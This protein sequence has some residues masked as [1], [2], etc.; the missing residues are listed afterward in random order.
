[1]PIMDEYLTRPVDVRLARLRST[2]EEL[3]SLLAGRDRPALTRRPD[4]GSW[5]AAE[6]VCHLRDAEEL[7]LVRFQTILAVD[8]PQILTL[9]A[10][11]EALR[12]PLDPDRWAEERQYARQDAGEALAAFG[13]RRREVIVLLDGLTAEQWQRRGIHQARGRMRLDEWVASLAVTTTI[14]WSSCGGRS[15]S[16]DP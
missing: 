10:T 4:P 8:D 2:P 3:A 12:H 14:T 16:L 6:I 7:F 9:G 13:R 15:S 1:M 5:S 11:P